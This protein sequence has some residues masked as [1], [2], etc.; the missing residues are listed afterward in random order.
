[1]TVSEED[2][3]ERSVVLDRLLQSQTFSSSESLRNILKFIVEKSLSGLDDE[4]KEYTIATIA[5]GK[6][7]DFDPTTDTSVRKQMHRL[8]QKIEK[9]Y[10][11][12]GSD[13]PLRIVVPLGHYAPEFQPRPNDVHTPT[14]AGPVV[15]PNARP[16]S[17]RL[18]K[19]RSISLPWGI[20][21]L[22]LIFI[23]VSNLRQRRAATF[24]AQPLSTTKLPA[25]LSP[26]WKGFLP[27]SAPPTIV[28]SN[29]PFMMSY[30]GD[31]YH[32]TINSSISIP[33]G[34][35]VPSLAGFGRQQ[36][37]PRG[38]GPLCYMDLYTGTGEVIAAAR[39]AQ[40]LT[41]ENQMF[42]IKRSLIVSYSDIR[43]TNVIFLG[44][45]N[46]DSILRQLPVESD[47]TFRRMHGVAAIND[48]YIYARHP[49]SGQP[50]SY[51]AVRDPKT[52]ALR[53][54]YA[55]V[56]F[57]PGLT[58]GH[59]IMV[60]AGITTIGTEAAADFVTSPDSMRILEK[61][62]PKMRTH[63]ALPYFQAIMKVQI[64]EG[65]VAKTTCILVRNLIQKSTYGSR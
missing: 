48:H 24:S 40:L 52:G 12:E 50:G 16:P 19:F 46:E 14:E 30:A 43:S 41:R 51:Y 39:I 47:F 23:S 2:H 65:E 32:F 64:R 11:E 27:P 59:Y 44:S 5:L 33:A 26:L 49:G 38:V 9:Y 1:M 29:A 8:R 22:L 13:D 31:L 25:A 37:L 34:A 18:D 4:I 62:R 42:A 3:H 17:E 28:Y 58:L 61:M 63:D 10:E 56:S 54:D 55:V 53:V 7:P 20:V 35:S 45:S 15:E 57:L 6:S 21:I 36:P 60:L